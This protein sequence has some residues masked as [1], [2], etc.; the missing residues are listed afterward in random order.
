MTSFRLPKPTPTQRLS[1]VI[2]ISFCFFVAEIAIGFSTHSLAVIADAFHYLTDLIGFI[3]ALT[4]LQVSQRAK[5]PKGFSFGWQ[6]AQLL[7]AFF[8]GVLLLGLGFSILL[9]SIERFISIQRVEEPKLVLIIGAVGLALNIISIVFL[10]DHD[11]DHNHDHGHDHADHLNTTSDQTQIRPLKAPAI[12]SVQSA[13]ATGESSIHIAHRHTTRPLTG[14][15]GRNLGIV[16]VLLH[17]V[18]DA[19]NNIGV[20]AAA[21]AIWWG[22]TEGRYYADPAI[23]MGIS[24]MIIG[25]S[26]PLIKRSGRILL[27]SGPNGVDIEEIRADLQEIPGVSSVHELHIWKLNEQKTVASAH[28]VVEDNNI[29]DFMAR[30]KM[31]G[32]CLHAYGVHSFTLQ[33]ERKIRYSTMSGAATAAM[34]SSSTADETVNLRLRT[35]ISSDPTCQLQCAVDSC[36]ALQCCE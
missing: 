19:I 4:A 33:P 25:T 24:F 27:Q 23:S 2:G 31:A 26:I 16:G 12:G 21:A 20:M 30:A 6:R 7:G 35:P 18:G 11:H 14:D 13:P 9:Q 34:T 1:V 29:D 10:H 28:L 15:S 17:V 22:K 32:E 5:S 8:N 36:L 3:I